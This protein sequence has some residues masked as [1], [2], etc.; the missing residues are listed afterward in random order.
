MDRWTQEGSHGFNHPI[1]I[2]KEK[3]GHVASLPPK[4]H[5]LN[6]TQ[7][8]ASLNQALHGVWRGLVYTLGS[9]PSTKSIN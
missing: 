2:F 4:S 9:I 7:L 3:L 1:D 5:D 6:P 8:E